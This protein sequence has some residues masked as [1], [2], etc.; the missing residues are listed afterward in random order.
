MATGS[1]ATGSVAKG[2]RPIG[3][4]TIK[5]WDITVAMLL[6][7]AEWAAVVVSVYFRKREP[8]AQDRKI[9]KTNNALSGG[10]SQCEK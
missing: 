10:G 9:D 6:A 8:R 4:P 5:R 2:L 7:E 1:A 3:R